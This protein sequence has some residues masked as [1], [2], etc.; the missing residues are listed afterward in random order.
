M[1]S[2]DTPLVA[3]RRAKLKAWIRDRHEGSRK[4][5]LEAVAVRGVTLNPTEVSNLQTGG[6]SFGEKKAAELET[7]AGMPPGYLVAALDDVDLLSHAERLDVAMIRHTIKR[8]REATKLSE[9]Q[10]VNVEADPEL[11]VELLRLSIIEA[12]ENGDGERG[13]RQAG[14]PGGR[15]S[16]T[17]GKTKDGGSSRAE[18]RPARKRA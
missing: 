13:V 8:M 18:D 3:A 17:A 12:R 7:A 5:F 10:A 1:P 4:L 15:T 14:G 16:G 6:K 2:A 9:G 11:F